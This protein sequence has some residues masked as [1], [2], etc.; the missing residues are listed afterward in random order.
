M[1]QI[2]VLFRIIASGWFII[3]ILS[4]FF[5]QDEAWI[6]FGSYEITNQ[7]VWIFLVIP[8]IIFNKLS[9]L[10]EI[11]HNRKIFGDSSGDNL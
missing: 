5:V 6:R 11:K 7:L 3:W 9:D 4:A 2:S 10:F 8:A 1:K